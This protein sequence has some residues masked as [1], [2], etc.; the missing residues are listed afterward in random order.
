MSFSSCF[1]QQRLHITVQGRFKQ[2]ISFAKVYTGQAWDEKLATTPPVLLEMLLTP[3]L[4]LLQPGMQINLTG[5]HP[6]ILSPLASTMQTIH[7]NVPGSEPILPKDIMSLQE[8]NLHL[9]GMDTVLT[10]NARKKF[11]SVKANLMKYEYDP[12]YIYTLN[13]YQHI[14]HIDTFTIFGY[15]ILRVLGRK[16]I[17]AM[18]IIFDPAEPE[19]EGDEV[20][21]AEGKGKRDNSYSHWNFL[22]KIEMWHERALDL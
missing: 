4:K 3:I 20:E 10:P 13:F 21:V 11:F 17:M 9:L 5:S 14:L 16:P 2:P 12:K 6:Y 1:S 19:N 22:Y 8:D 18:A 7:I 15:D